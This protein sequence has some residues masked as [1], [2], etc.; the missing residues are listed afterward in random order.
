MVNCS[1][2][3]WP[4]YMKMIAAGYEDGNDDCNEVNVTCS[5][6][7]SVD[8]RSMGRYFRLIELPTPHPNCM[9]RHG[10]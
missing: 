7:I 3:A 10:T 8:L 5:V 6:R 4:R 9:G 1:A 2:T